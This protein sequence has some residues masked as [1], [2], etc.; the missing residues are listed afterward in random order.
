MSDQKQSPIIRIAVLKSKNGR[1]IFERVTREGKLSKRAAKH[2]G[3]KKVTSWTEVEA[4]SWKSATKLV[5]AGR[6]RKV[7]P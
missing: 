5:R 6:G 7:A 1:E 4:R 2:L 3:T